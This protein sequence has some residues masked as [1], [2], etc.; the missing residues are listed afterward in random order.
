MTKQYAEEQ[1]RHL[2]KRRKIMKLYDNGAGKTP[3]EIG[4]L[5]GISR[6][7]VSQIVH[8]E[9]ERDKQVG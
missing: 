8:K 2:A 9:I 5:L 6:Q 4:R 1:K 3:A 7:R